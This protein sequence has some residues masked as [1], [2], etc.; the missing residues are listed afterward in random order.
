MLT[1]KLCQGRHC[2]QGQPLCHEGQLCHGWQI[3]LQHGRQHCQR[4]ATLPRRVM[5]P[6]RAPCS[7]AASMQTK[8]ISAA[9]GDFTKEVEVAKN[10]DLLFQEK[11]VCRGPQHHHEGQLCRRWLPP[12]Q[13][14][15]SQGLFTEIVQG[16]QLHGGRGLPHK[17]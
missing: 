10:G 4:W 12:L 16:R 17:G 6:Q 5:L 1:V 3:G 14:A 11:Q 8:A 2:S 9:E 7:G 13:Q 15:T